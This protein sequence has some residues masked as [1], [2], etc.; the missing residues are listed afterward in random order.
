MASE[1]RTGSFSHAGAV[2]ARRVLLELGT[3]TGVATAWLLDGMDEH[4]RLIT[5]EQDQQVAVVAQ[6]HLGDDP[7]VTCHVEDAA[8][9]LTRLA[10]EAIRPDLADTWVG[11]Y[12]HLD[13]ALGLLKEGGL[14]VIDDMLP[15]KQTGRTDTRRRCVS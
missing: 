12:T 7:R 3:G 15:Q 6:A 10:D 9:V 5:I 14:Y 2:E 8:A 11:K 13:E 1:P 4:A